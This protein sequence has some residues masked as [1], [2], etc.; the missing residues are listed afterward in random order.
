MLRAELT[1]FI[2]PNKALILI[3]AGPETFLNT[4]TSK[5]CFFENCPVS[6]SF[7]HSWRWLFWSDL[8]KLGISLICASFFIISSVLK[9]FK[10]NLGM[11]RIRAKSQ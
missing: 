8:Y 10:L 4:G 11:I 9:V 2:L 3:Y 6:V 5:S 7:R 1:I